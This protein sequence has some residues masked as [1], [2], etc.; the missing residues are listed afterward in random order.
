MECELFLVD[1]L[2]RKQIILRNNYIL[3]RTRLSFEILR[4]VQ[5]RVTFCKTDTP[6]IHDPL[7]LLDFWHR[8]VS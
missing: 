1:K 8:C 7:D 3:A 2:S 6:E 5:L 4:S